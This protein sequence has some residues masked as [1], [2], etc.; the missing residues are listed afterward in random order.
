MIDR[1][2]EISVLEDNEVLTR[3]I[4][5]IVQKKRGIVSRLKT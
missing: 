1:A 4:V 5:V 2:C 3:H